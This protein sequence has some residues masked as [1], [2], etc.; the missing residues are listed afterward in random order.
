MM[1]DRAMTIGRVLLAIAATSCIGIVAPRSATADAWN[2]ETVVTFSQDVAIPGRVLP[3][4]QYIFRIADSRTNR[5][6]VQVFDRAGKILATVFTIPT[7]RLTAT[8]DTHI[9]FN[10]QRT[11]LAVPIKE[12]FYPGNING[13]EFMYRSHG[14]MIATAR[15]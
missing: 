2:K 6:T 8:D 5:H 4:G 3:A 9:T 14:A 7:V 11:G 13:E 12:W 10:E 1:G 15:R